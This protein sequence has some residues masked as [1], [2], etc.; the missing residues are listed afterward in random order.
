MAALIS[1][2]AVVVSTSQAKSAK[3]Q[4]EAAER[5]TALQERMHQDA[6]QPYVHADFRVHPQEGVLL[7]LVI[8]NSGPTV[9]TDVD[10]RFEPPLQSAEEDPVPSKHL[11]SLPPG[12]RLAWTFASGL[13]V[14]E[15][16][17][18]KRFTVTI[19]GTGPFGPLPVLSYDLDLQDFYNTSAKPEGT[20]H[21][22]AKSVEKVAEAVERAPRRPA[23]G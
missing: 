7:M 15:G 16:D 20:L 8:A 5:Q 9:A 22:I 13:T 11:A 18:P 21:S 14:F 12:R 10:V 23:S 4:A 17:Y 19:T 1:V 6:A 3:R 2:G